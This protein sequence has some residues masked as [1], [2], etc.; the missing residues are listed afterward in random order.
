ML[1]CHGG[2]VFARRVD[3]FMPQNICNQVNIPGM[4]IEHR[5][6]CAAQLVRRDVLE[7]GGQPR[8][9][10]DHIFYSA[11]SYPVLLQRKKER[12]REGLAA[13]HFSLLQIFGQRF[14]RLVIKI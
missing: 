14:F 9:L 8:I 13:L 12:G 11:G 2:I 6:V 1:F 10:F 3:V 7:W 5:A 4:L